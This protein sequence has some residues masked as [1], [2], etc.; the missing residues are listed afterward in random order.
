MCMYEWS[1]S[2]HGHLVSLTKNE[3]CDNSYTIF[4]A[5]FYGG[6]YLFQKRPKICYFSSQKTDIVYF[7]FFQKWT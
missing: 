1:I 5:L 4:I 6:V 3:L 2:K 7:G